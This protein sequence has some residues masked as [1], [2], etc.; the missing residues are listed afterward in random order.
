[1]QV[2]QGKLHLHHL[3]PPPIS[4]ISCYRILKQRLK[5]NV[6]S[7]ILWYVLCII[8]LLGRL[9]CQESWTQSEATLQL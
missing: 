6:R 7:V 5:T 4:V 2:G 3:K 8:Y 9:T 1:M